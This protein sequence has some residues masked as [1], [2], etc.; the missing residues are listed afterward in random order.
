MEGRCYKIDHHPYKR[1]A[2]PEPTTIVI[3]LGAGNYRFWG[4]WFDVWGCGMIRISSSV[5]F[6]LVAAVAMALPGM[7]PAGSPA[8]AGQSPNPDQYGY[9]WIDNQ[10]P[11]NPG[12][13]GSG[14]VFAQI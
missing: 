14:P 4:V 12:S 9:K 11:D 3:R 8:P 1:F 6:A 13:G 5:R 10:G 7:S 2:N